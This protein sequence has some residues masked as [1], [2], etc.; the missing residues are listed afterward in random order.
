MVP[1]SPAALEIPSK[2]QH[3][4]LEIGGS[5]QNLVTLQDVA[6][7][8]PGANPNAHPVRIEFDNSVSPPNA[9]FKDMT[10]G[11]TLAGRMVGG[12]LVPFKPTYVNGTNDA[13]FAAQLA[14]Q[15]AVEVQ[16]NNGGFQ[17]SHCTVSTDGLILLLN[18]HN[19][20]VFA[21]LIAPKEFAV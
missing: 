6:V 19:F 17:A 20:T 1:L 2:E 9:S 18:G 21:T 13:T 10:T 16:G 5:S 8:D 7:G 11:V 15:C 14:D 4:V 3:M 12:V